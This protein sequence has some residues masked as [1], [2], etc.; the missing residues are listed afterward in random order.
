MGSPEEYEPRSVLL[1]GAAGFIGAH[2]ANRLVEQLPH[3]KVVGLDRLDYCSSRKSLRFALSKPNFKLV[4]GCV[5]Q[6]DL[7]NFLMCNEQVDTVLH[8]AAQTHVDTS[9]GSS[10][11]YT[12]SNVYGTHVMLECARACGTVRR[13]LHVS[14]DEVY[15]E[16]GVTTSGA[17]IAS[18]HGS[19]ESHT[20]LQPT[21]PYS[22][23]KAAAEMLVKAYS[24]SYN[25]PA[26]I[27]RGNNV[28]GPQQFP[29]KLV[30]PP[31]P[32]SLP[33]PS[34]SRDFSSLAPKLLFLADPQILGACAPWKEA[35]GSWLR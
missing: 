3:T 27:T 29:D 25:L 19:S 2:L 11:S 1:T 14:T 21:N 23:T 26:I 17:S 20:T 33:P 4:V 13:F 18:F 30:R 10:F 7:V 35:P 22:A 32:P 6:R 24:C 15:G 31:P 28:Y 9:F 16:S 5:T 12:Q 8:L 34:R